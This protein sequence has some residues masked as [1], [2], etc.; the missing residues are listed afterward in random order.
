MRD[1]IVITV[2]SDILDDL[3]AK[4]G[5]GAELLNRAAIEAYI[6]YDTEE[7]SYIDAATKLLLVAVGYLESSVPH[8]DINTF[9]D[10]DA[11]LTDLLKRHAKL[12]EYVVR[13]AGLLANN[14]V[15]KVG[16]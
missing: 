16:A 12:T 5:M 6:L 1:Q 9:A 7:H 13:S 4:S 2:P 14:A 8:M 11:V 10:S 15:V 3:P